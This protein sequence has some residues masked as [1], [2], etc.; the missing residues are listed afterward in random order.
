VSGFE[1]PGA[2][3]SV[4][5]HRPGRHAKKAWLRKEQDIGRVAQ[6]RTCSGEEKRMHGHLKGND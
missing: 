5:G 2:L 3:F 6:S 4:A 1:L